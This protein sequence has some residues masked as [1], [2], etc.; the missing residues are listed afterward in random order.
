[1][2]DFDVIMKSDGW[3]EIHDRYFFKGLFASEN[4]TFFNRYV[5]LWQE[6]KGSIFDQ[7]ERDLDNYLESDLRKAIDASIIMNNDRWATEMYGLPSS[8]TFIEEAK[9]YLRQQKVWLESAIR[10]L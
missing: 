2:W 3:D 10:N 7:L 6:M 5:T 8:E 9:A 1:M 4:R